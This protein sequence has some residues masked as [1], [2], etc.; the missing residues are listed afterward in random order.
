M[1]NKTLTF[2]P[3]QLTSV[4]LNPKHE[5]DVWGRGT[6]KSNKHGWKMDRIIKSMP[7][8]SSVITG[9]TYTQLL[10]RTLPPMISFLERMGYIRNKDFFIG[11]KSPKS[12]AWREP[13]EAPLSY[14]HYMIFGNPNG[15][16]GFHLASQ[17]RVGSGRGLNTDF[18]LTDEA[19]TLDIDRYNKEIHATNRG[20]LD[21]FGKIP[22]HHGTHHSTSM[23]YS[24]DGKWLLEAG[25][26]YD[27]EAGIRY[28][29]L[30]NRVVKMQLDLLEID[31]PKEFA[32]QWNEIQLIRRR[33]TP[34]VS[35][36]GMLFTLANA[37]D[38]I[39]N[40]GYSYIKEQY[41]TTP[42]L[43]FLIEIMNMIIDKVEDCYYAID[44]DKHV[45][46]D[47]YNYSH[48]D[49]LDYDFKKLGS[50][51]SQFDKDVDPNEP[52][53]ML[54]DWGSSI[55]WL[56]IAQDNCLVDPDRRLTKNYVK[57]FYAKQQQGRVMIDDV[58]DDFCKYY[59]Y[60]NDKTVIYYKDKYGDARRA[61]S[62]DTYNQQAINRLRDKGW[63]VI[64]KEEK[65][66]EPPHH[67][68]YLLWNN[69][70]KENNDRF[71]IV[72][73]NGNNCKFLIIAMQNTKVYERSGKFEKDKS[74]EHKNS[75]TPVEEATHSTDAAD[76]L[77]WVDHKST[78]S[79]GGFIETRI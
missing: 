19:L 20:N 62:S 58:V 57:E 7:R 3:A 79:G 49:N 74:S 71:P 12:W 42:R 6:G 43:T 37:F 22:W 5:V 60:H 1:A 32:A 26:Y 33:M 11:K 34:F 70:F 13:Y 8:S 76:K 51:D 78:K 50:P 73:F 47:S 67:E 2:N 64:L 40:V 66:Q 38:N 56:I 31:K 23:P 36:D 44:G 68:K 72:R 46:Y 21:R 77:L 16:V 63:N 10:T 28:K 39:E 55:S 75:K 4:L 53:K 52:L 15:S 65:A 25:D 24:K 30:W 35:K 54:Q 69:S 41:R 27:I 14:E 59:R 17:D 48:I 9:K 29:E 61:N 18:E 45:Y